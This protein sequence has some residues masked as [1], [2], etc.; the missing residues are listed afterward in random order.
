[1]ILSEILPG[2]THRACP[3]RKPRRFSP[4]RKVTITLLD[5]KLEQLHTFPQLCESLEQ[6]Y[7]RFFGVRTSTVMIPVSVDMINHFMTIVD[8]TGM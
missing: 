6:K 8:V 1:M 7:E 3:L 5:E 2:S 4:P